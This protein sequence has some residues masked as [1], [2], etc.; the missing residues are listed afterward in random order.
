MTVHSLPKAKPPAGLLRRGSDGKAYWEPA[1]IVT[2]GAPARSAAPKF[3]MEGYFGFYVLTCADGPATADGSCKF[4]SEA[5]TVDSVLTTMSVQAE[6]ANY[7]FDRG[8]AKTLATQIIEAAAKKRA[9]EKAAKE[10]AARKCAEEEEVK[11]G[12]ALAQRISN[13]VRAN[14]DPARHFEE[15]AGMPMPAVIGVLLNLKKSKTLEDFRQASIPDRIWA[16]ILT[17][18]EDFGVEWQRV[19]ARLHDDKDREALVA[20][21]PANVSPGAPPALEDG[22]LE[23]DRTEIGVSVMF[24][25]SKKGPWRRTEGDKSKDESSIEVEGEY[26]IKIVRRGRFSFEASASKIKGSITLDE[27]SGKPR[28][29]ELSAGAQ[30]S[31]NIELVKD[32][33]EAAVFGGLAAGLAR[34]EENGHWESKFVRQTSGGAELVFS[35]GKRVKLVFQ[36]EFSLSKQRGKQ[37]EPLEGGIGGGAGFKVVF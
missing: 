13:T 6:L 29:W 5:T 1:P 19:V 11:K 26:T 27:K 10:A 21:A 24:V 9:E 33:I 34:E 30:V 37:H 23:A 36:S 3:W 17:V 7:T 14:G 15:L 12:A 25:K 4:N 28:G 18:E 16:A 35:L 20:R 2:W 22:K 32:C 8:A 31:L